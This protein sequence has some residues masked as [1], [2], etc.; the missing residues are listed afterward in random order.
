MVDALRG[1]A[2]MGLFLVHCVE[3]FELYW[4]DPVPDGWFDAV[5]AV[6]AGKAFAVFALLFGFGFATIMGNERQRGGDFTLRFAWRLVLLLAIGTTHAL[7]YRGDILQ[8]LALV[9]LVM[10]P[11]DRVRS[12]RVLLL[13]AAL[14][15]LQ[16]PLLW[17]GIAAAGGAGWAQAN[18]LFFGDSGLAVLADGTLGQMLAVNLG[19]GM[20]GKWSFYVETGRVVE[21]AG[22]FLL[23]M[24][25]QRRGLFSDAAGHGK[26][27]AGVLVLSVIAWLAISWAEPRLLRS[28]EGAPM[29]RQ[30]IEWATGQWRALAATAF[31]VSAFVLLWLGAARPLLG[32]LAA[33]GRMTLT[34]Y[35][36]QSLL[37]VPLL[38]GFGA[39]L[40]EDLNHAQLVLAGLGLFALQAAGAALWF[41][42]FRYGP[43]EWLWRAGTRM[44]LAVPMRQPPMN[45]G[46]SGH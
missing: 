9:G 24:V 16:V 45:A 6:F 22:L 40:H 35:V 38:Y 8:V 17:R 30:S 2:L 29:Y 36:G 37:C 3:R 26:F 13:I 15:F 1:W 4:L 23:G 41:H 27:W 7:A 32:W 31:H 39:G 18:P 10:I 25:I 14:L 21:I 11:F 42:H 12:S 28:S 5:F 20:V 46:T 43:L 19:P 34:L 33:P 44:T